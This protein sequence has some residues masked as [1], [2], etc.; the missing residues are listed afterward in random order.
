MKFLIKKFQTRNQ[1]MKAF[2]VR[3]FASSRRLRKWFKKWVIN[4]ENFVKRN[5]CFYVS[6]DAIVKEKFIK[7][8]HDN[9]LSEHFEVQKTLNLIQR[10]YYWIVCAKQIKM[11]VKTYNVCQRIKVSRHKFYKKLSFL[12][13]SEVSWKKILWILLSICR[14]ASAI[15]SYIIQFS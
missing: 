9:S 10:K 13:I 2:Y 3:K 6:N 1:W 8:H 11:Y 7:K 12:F 5:E 15:K 14:R 4:D